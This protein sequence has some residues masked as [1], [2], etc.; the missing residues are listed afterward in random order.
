MVYLQRLRGLMLAVM[1]AALMSDLTSIFNSSSTLFTVDLYTHFRRQAKNRELMIVGRVFVLVMVGLSILWVPV[2]QSM[3]GGQLYIYIQSVSGFLSPP[4]A[5]V[6]LMALLWKRNNELGAFTGLIYGFLI[7]ITRMVLSFVYPDPI[8]GEPDTRPWIVSQVHYMYFAMFS[9]FSTAAVMGL[10]SLCSSPPTEEQ[11]R[12]LTFWTRKDATSSSPTDHVV[13]IS[14]EIKLDPVDD[15]RDKT[16]EE[17]AQGGESEKDA[18]LTK[19]SDLDKNF[20]ERTSTITQS[21]AS[22]DASVVDGQVSEGQGLC[23]SCLH[24]S[25]HMCQWFW[26]CTDQ[27]CPED[28]QCCC[29]LKK[30]GSN[31]QGTGVETE[32]LRIVPISLYQTRSAKIGLTIGLVV[33]ITTTVFLFCFFSLYFGPITRGPLTVVGSTT[34]ANISGAISDLMAFGIIANLTG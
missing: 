14:E 18:G 8:C 30:K 33:I 4:I 20:D 27:P 2:I 16:G 11:V 6:Y 19:R 25:G 28:V 34:S 22:E 32:P 10:V 3:Q 1:L 24:V 23:V 12:G 13:P 5:A 31:D 29:C 17:R 15:S 21:D 26:G 9:F 7:G